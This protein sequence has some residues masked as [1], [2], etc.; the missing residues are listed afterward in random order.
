[1]DIKE[2]RKRNEVL[3]EMLEILDVDNLIEK[4]VD[5]YI[6]KIGGT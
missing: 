4:M 5:I 6:F 1:M 3:F 2:E